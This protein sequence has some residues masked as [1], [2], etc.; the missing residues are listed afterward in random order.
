VKR[1]RSKFCE[2]HQDHGHLTS[3]YYQLKRQIEA[4]IQDGKLKEYVLRTIGM[5]AA[6]GERPRQERK[7]PATVTVTDR[8]AN[9][10]LES[11]QMHV[12]G[13]ILGGP[14]FGDSS[15]QRKK[16]VREV[17]QGKIAHYIIRTYEAPPPAPFKSMFFTSQEVVRVL[18]GTVTQ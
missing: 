14:E 17:S 2:Y 8:E 1:D 10:E 3:E 15:T 4:L 12:V 9:Q 11:S 16:Y 6:N 7:G 13:S 18:H 5:A